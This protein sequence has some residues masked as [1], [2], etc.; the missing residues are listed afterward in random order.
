MRRWLQ[1]SDGEAAGAYLN[2][3]TPE[4]YFHPVPIIVLYHPG[5]DTDDVL[6]TMDFGCRTRPERHRQP[7][8]G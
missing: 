7:T 4:G 1:L 8:V 5:A 6:M 3:S 2:F